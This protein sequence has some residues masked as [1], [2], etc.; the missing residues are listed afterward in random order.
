MSTVKLNMKQWRAA[1]LSMGNAFWVAARRGA[2]AAAA[3]SI[4]HLVAAGD[5]TG[6]VNT[7]NFRR[8]WR[9]RAI[10]VGAEIFNNA[11]Y[12]GVIEYGRRKGAR[13][14]PSEPIARWVQ[15]KLGKS[16]EES[17]SIAFLIARKIA[18]DGIPAQHIL[19]DAES[20]IRRF[21]LEEVK[22]EVSAAGGAVFARGVK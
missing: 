10:D 22:A 6:R 8:N 14:P 18:R 15:R 7:G 3:R 19:R 1:M 2:V 5:A 17:Q 13:Q 21:L 16:R 9:S 11:P 12:A 4:P 20:T